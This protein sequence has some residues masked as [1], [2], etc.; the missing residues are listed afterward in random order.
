MNIQLES[1][2]PQI[3]TENN[4]RQSDEI[5]NTNMINERDSDEGDKIVENKEKILNTDIE[6]L[7]LRKL[8]SLKNIDYIEK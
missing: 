7:K 4:N 5:Y 1:L 2:R 6:V 8:I 3:N